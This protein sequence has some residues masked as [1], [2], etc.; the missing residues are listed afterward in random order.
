[1]LTNKPPASASP[2]KLPHRSALLQAEHAA[3]MEATSREL[4]EQAATHAAQLQAKLA[5]LTA[6]S[7][8]KVGCL[9]ACLPV[10]YV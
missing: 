1:M 10:A 7:E 2:P 5:E 8:A 6:L 4:E 3:A 9:P